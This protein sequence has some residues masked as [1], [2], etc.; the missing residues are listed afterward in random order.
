MNVNAVF[1]LSQNI[2]KRNALNAIN[3][4][5]FLYVEYLYSNHHIRLPSYTLIPLLHLR[6]KFVKNIKLNYKQL[7]IFYDLLINRV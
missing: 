7:N 3:S 2:I 5:V 4:K 1:L 6:L